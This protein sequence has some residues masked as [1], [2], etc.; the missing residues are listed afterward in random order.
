LRQYFDRA[1]A[2]A[3]LQDAASE[4]RISVR[5]LQRALSDAGSSFRRELARARVERAATLLA[6]T[7]DK[8][9]AIARR[10]GCASTSHLWV[11]FRRFGLGSPIEYRQKLRRE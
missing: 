4:L 6:M 8:V 11:L 2:D 3:A 10:V 5:T 9:A 7:D 1:L